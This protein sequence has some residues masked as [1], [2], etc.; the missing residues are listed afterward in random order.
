VIYLKRLSFG[1]LILDEKLEKGQ[2]RPLT[3]QEI[4]DLKK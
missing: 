3:Q 1:T 2:F 4:L